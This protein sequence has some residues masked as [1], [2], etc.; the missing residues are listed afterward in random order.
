MQIC[1]ADGLG[2]DKHFAT[3]LIGA[4]LVTKLLQATLL[5]VNNLCFSFTLFSLR[6]QPDEMTQ[7]VLQHASY[8]LGPSAERNSRVL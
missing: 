5:R 6:L 4:L 2:L 7:P 8:W 3:G 1:G